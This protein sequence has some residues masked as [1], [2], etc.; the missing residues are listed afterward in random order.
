MNDSE[1]V[2]ISFEVM[3]SG[4]SRFLILRYSISSNPLISFVIEFLVCRGDG[5]SPNGGKYVVGDNVTS[6][7]GGGG[8]RGSLEPGKQYDGVVTLSVGQPG[9][10]DPG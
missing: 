9:S 2:I 10:V 8:H 4:I 3:S 7:S 1:N 6:P 5:F